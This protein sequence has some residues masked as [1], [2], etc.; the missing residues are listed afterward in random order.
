MKKTMGFL[1]LLALSLFSIS[2][3]GDKTAGVG[4]DPKA[5]VI[6][7]GKRIGKKDFN[8]AAKL[9]SAE[10]QEFIQM[11]AQAMKMAENFKTKPNQKKDPMANFNNAEI[12]DAVI[13]GETAVVPFKN[14]KEGVE[15]EFPLVKENGSWKVYFTSETMAKMSRQSG[16]DVDPNSFEELKKLDPDQM[17]KA[18]EVAQ[19]VMSDPEKMK[20]LQEM[21]KEFGDPKN[22]EALEKMMKQADP[23]KLKQMQEMMKALQD[24]LK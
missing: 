17:K 22:A 7:F 23:E 13:T 8:G 12:G 19:D 20:M 14:K 11:A 1:C 15:F 6:E 5:V 3:C 24:T 21:S 9:A 2:S 16:H 10:S 18:L 4:N